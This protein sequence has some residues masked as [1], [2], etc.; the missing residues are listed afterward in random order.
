M[1]GFEK[2]EFEGNAVNVSYDHNLT[3]ISGSIAETMVQNLKSWIF[4]C[5]TQRQD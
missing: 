3:K 4:V 2:I 5:K 1:S